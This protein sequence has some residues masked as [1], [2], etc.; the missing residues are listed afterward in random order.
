MGAT[1]GTR[2]L[3]DTAKAAVNRSG[4]ALYAD[5]LVGYGTPDGSE[6][7]VD[8]LHT[9][10]VTKVAGAIQV[11]PDD[12][13]QVTVY[14]PGSIVKLESDGSG[15]IAYGAD[16]IAVAGASVAAG[17]RVKTLPGSTGSYVLV[18]KS[19]TKSTVAATAGLKVL[20]E[21]CHPTP[22]YVA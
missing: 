3:P 10:G 22:V 18:G 15:T 12:D 16:V 9:T 14:G 1:A 5:R 7:A 20:V 11:A 19:R 6:D 13:G 17:G 21:L 8:S 4:G 2:F